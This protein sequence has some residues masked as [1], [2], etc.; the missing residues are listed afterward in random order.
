MEYRLR[1][2]NEADIPAIAALIAHS[3]RQ[4][5]TEDY[6]PAQIEGALMGAFGVDTLLIRDQTYFVVVTDSGALVACGG[7]SKR[8]TLFG[9]DARAERD[10]GWLDPYGVFI[11]AGHEAGNALTAFH[12]GTKVICSPPGSA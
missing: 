10:E 3:I 5:G 8:R 9:G 6:T 4:L 7:W 2:A 11:P 1:K 12:M